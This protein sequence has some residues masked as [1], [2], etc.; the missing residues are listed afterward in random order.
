MLKGSDK[1]ELFRRSF[2]IGMVYAVIGVIAVMVVGH[3]QAQ[4]M[5]KVQP[6]KMAAAEALWETENPAAMSLFTV[7]NEAERRDVIAFK[8]TGLLSKASD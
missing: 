7:G 1:L 8:V 5:V 6:M 3:N 2:K 4:Y